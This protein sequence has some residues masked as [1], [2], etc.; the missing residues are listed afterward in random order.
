M[1][2]LLHLTARI[3]SRITATEQSSQPRWVQSRDH[4]KGLSLPSS[5]V[6]GL[7][8]SLSKNVFFPQTWK[9]P[10]TVY[11]PKEDKDLSDPTPTANLSTTTLRKI[12]DEMCATVIAT[13]LE[14]NGVLERMSVGSMPSTR[15]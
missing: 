7:I 6:T 14:T 10:I 5:V 2:L 1:G 9:L 13:Y 15:W 4:P 11:F 8:Q 3:C 12:L